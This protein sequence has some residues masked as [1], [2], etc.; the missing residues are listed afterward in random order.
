MSDPTVTVREQVHSGTQQLVKYH[1]PLPDLPP[2]T[3][4]LTQEPSLWVDCP[5][6]RC[7]GGQTPVGPPSYWQ[8]CDQ[9]HGEGRVL[10]PEIRER[11]KALGVPRSGRDYDA[12]LDVVVAV[13]MEG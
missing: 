2:G 9:C 4:R 13:L 6:R 1:D 8:S 10:N 3:Y 5:N 7:V 11:I 12:W